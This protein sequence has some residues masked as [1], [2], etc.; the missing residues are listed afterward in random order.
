MVAA[1]RD[2]GLSP[3]YSSA[4][5]PNQDQ[6][7]HGGTSEGPEGGW[8]RWREGQGLANLLAMALYGAW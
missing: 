4:Q 1:G 6:A 2:V 5:I 8:A 7:N 3:S